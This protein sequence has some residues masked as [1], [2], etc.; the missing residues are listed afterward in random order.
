[1]LLD[2]GANIN[3]ENQYGITP[4][5]IAVEYF[6]MELTE[7]LVNQGTDVNATNS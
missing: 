5:H 4:I 3:A 7:L 2:R 1:M 6:G